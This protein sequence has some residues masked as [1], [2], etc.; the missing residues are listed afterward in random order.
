VQWRTL[1]AQKHTDTKHTSTQQ[2]AKPHRTK[3]TNQQPRIQTSPA[4]NQA[5]I[6]RSLFL[7]GAISSQARLVYH[8]Q[9]NKRNEIVQ[10]CFVCLMRAASFF[11]LIAWPGVGGQNLSLRALA[12]VSARKF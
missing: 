12:Y 6:A 9:T 11:C 1:Y 2:R 10:R 4:Q 3:T 7:A 8:E 5:A